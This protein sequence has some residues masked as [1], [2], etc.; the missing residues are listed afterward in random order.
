MPWNSSK[1]DINTKHAIFLSIHDWLVQVVKDYAS[2][3]RVWMGDWPDKVFKYTT[4]T[5]KEIHI[6]D[7]PKV[8]NRSFRL[9]QNLGQ[10]MGMS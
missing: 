7:F 3:S 1:S 4:G 10:D 2:L 9:F 8:K 5:I 6:D